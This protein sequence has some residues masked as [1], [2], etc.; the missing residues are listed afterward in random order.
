LAAIACLKATSG[1]EM[2]SATTAPGLYTIDHSHPAQARRC[3][4]A[5]SLLLSV[6]KEVLTFGLY[7]VAHT[8]VW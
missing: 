6:A 4:V 7:V 2:L 5:I 8:F 3:V 1:A